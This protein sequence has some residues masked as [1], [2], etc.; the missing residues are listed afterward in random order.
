MGDR[1]SK[2]EGKGKGE[3]GRDRAGSKDEMIPS[4]GQ[5]TRPRGSGIRVRKKLRAS[6]QSRNPG[7]HRCPP[8]S[9]SPFAL[10][11]LTIDA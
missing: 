5:R 10:M 3:A 8:N 9:R 1:S 7:P 2:G 11:S 4:R 6:R